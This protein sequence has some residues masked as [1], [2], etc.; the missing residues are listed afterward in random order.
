MPSA[1]LFDDLKLMPAFS[2]K[3]PCISS[4]VFRCIHKFCR[5]KGHQIARGHISVTNWWFFQRVCLYP[6]L[7]GRWFPLSKNIFSTECVW[8]P[9][10]Q[11]HVQG[12]INVIP[13]ILDLPFLWQKQWVGNQHLGISTASRTPHLRWWCIACDIFQLMT[14]H[15][16]YH[17]S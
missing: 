5:V 10:H 17:A 8:P 16:S 2:D 13:S 4:F 11:V 12:Y 14:L 15:Q 3:K 1:G 9:R 7:V 6:L